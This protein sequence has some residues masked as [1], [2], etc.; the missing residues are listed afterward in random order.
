MSRAPCEA[1]PAERER[2]PLA[3]VRT[4][5]VL[6]AARGKEINLRL[7]SGREGVGAGRCCLKSAPP[8]EEDLVPGSEWTGEGSHIA[9]MGQGLESRE[10]GRWANISCAPLSPWAHLRVG[11]GAG[12]LDMLHQLLGHSGLQ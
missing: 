1:W 2:T 11:G 5:T 7:P 8:A 6:A 4:L 9:V 3:C 12:W 10:A